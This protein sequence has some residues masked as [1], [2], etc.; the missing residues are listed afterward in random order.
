MNRIPRAP[1]ASAISLSFPCLPLVYMGLMVTA[2]L[3]S[4]ASSL[5][6][7][8]PSSVSLPTDDEKRDAQLE[9]AAE[10]NGR[11]PKGTPQ[12]KHELAINLTRQAQMSREEGDYATAKRMARKALF[13][14]STLDKPFAGDT[15]RLASINELSA[16]LADEFLGMEQQAQAYLEEALRLDPARELAKERLALRKR[17]NGEHPVEPAAPTANP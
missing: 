17:R 2:P 13:I 16:Y 3:S 4:L 8:A 6:T 15:Q 11:E 10:E 7:S 5:A 1:F 14:L 12:A 9:K